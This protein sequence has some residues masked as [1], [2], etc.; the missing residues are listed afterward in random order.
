MVRIT[1]I[2]EEIIQIDGHEFYDGSDGSVGRESSV[3][4]VTGYGLGI[5]SRWGPDFP[6]LSWGPPSLLYN[7][8]LVFLGVKSGRAVTLTPHPF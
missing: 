5:E 6:H 4:I 8:Y 1:Y 2:R 7:G 3:V